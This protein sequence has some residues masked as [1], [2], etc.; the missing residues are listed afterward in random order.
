MTDAKA[1]IFSA[2]SKVVIGNKEFLIQRH[3]SGK[4]DFRQAIFSAVENEAKQLNRRQKRE[5]ESA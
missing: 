2:C 3:F 4:R 1:D 5:K